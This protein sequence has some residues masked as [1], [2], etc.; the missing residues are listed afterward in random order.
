[1]SPDSETLLSELRRL[2]AAFP[3]GLVAVGDMAV[4]LHAINDGV[5]AAPASSIEAYLSLEHVST[6]RDEVEVV[7][8]PEAYKR[9]ALLPN[10]QIDLY[11]ER[12]HRLAVPYEDAHRYLARTRPDG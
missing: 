1:M 4:L 11:V 8:V 10:A 9:R 6:V 5:E 7:R 3:E 12:Q 2:N